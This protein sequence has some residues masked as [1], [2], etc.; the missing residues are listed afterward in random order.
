M[1]ENLRR[2]NG[3]INTKNDLI[4]F[5][6]EIINQVAI[7]RMYKGE[8]VS[9]IKDAKILIDKIFEEIDNI[10]GIKEKQKQGIDHSA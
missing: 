6:Y 4:N 7:E 9:H 2:L 8:D 3:D 10:Y 1:S 5:G